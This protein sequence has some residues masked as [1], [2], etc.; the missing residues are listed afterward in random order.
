[1]MP[2]ACPVVRHVRCYKKESQLVV[3]AER[4]RSGKSGVVRLELLSSKR[5]TPWDEPMASSEVVLPPA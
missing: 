1:M 5:E 4:V 3:S 2:R